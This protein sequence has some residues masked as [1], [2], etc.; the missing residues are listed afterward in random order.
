M[1]RTTFRIH[2]AGC[3][4]STLFASEHLGS[5]TSL[6]LYLPRR[7]LGRSPTT[8][9]ATGSSSRASSKTSSW[10]KVQVEDRRCLFGFVW[11]RW[12]SAQS[13][14]VLLVQP[15]IV[16]LSISWEMNWDTRSLTNWCPSSL[17]QLRWS[18]V[19]LG[20]HC[21]PL[22]RFH[23]ASARKK[24]NNQGGDSWAKFSKVR[25]FMAK[26]PI[27]KLFQTCLQLCAHIEKS[28]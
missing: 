24:N 12:R 23:T 19:C 14:S 18:A 2:P 21:T 20:V 8:T 13:R 4:A 5:A 17:A 27:S 10:Q 15:R 28:S 9:G 26:K 25:I 3:W 6:S 22:P 16:L 7:G 11:D 1:T